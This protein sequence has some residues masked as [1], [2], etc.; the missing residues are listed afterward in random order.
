MG[1]R[2]STPVARR[3]LHPKTT[4][5][6]HSQQA[7]PLQTSNSGKKRIHR[8]QPVSSSGGVVLSAVAAS[9]SS[10]RPTGIGAT[11]AHGR[12]VAGK[13]FGRRECSSRIVADEQI[14]NR[15]PS[16]L[17]SFRHPGLAL[18]PAAPWLGNS[19]VETKDTENQRR[20]KTSQGSKPPFAWPQSG[21][22]R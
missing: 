11:V 3:S 6:P 14:R 13:V 2:A 15:G 19:S 7:S 16:V 9:L 22:R 21:V 12:D 1:C 5:A 17:E 18:V 20:V 8:V 10:V 4:P